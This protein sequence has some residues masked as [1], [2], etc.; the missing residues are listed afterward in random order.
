MRWH[1]EMQHVSAKLHFLPSEC[2]S[3]TPALPA[4]HSSNTGVSHSI[5]SSL[6]LGHWRHRF[7]YTGFPYRPGA[8]RGGLL[9]HP[10]VLPGCIKVSFDPKSQK[11]VFSFRTVFTFHFLLLSTSHLPQ[12]SA[13]PRWLHSASFAL[14]FFWDCR[15]PHHHSSVQVSALGDKIYI[16]LRPLLNVICLPFLVTIPKPFVNQS[17]NNREVLR[18]G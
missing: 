18:R 1:A 6:S 4:A 9:L 2:V 13:G 8:P 15:R 10:E 12:R 17:N 5:H 16:H 3:L 14:P 7:R 11:S